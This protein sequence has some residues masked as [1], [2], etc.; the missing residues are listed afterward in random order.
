MKKLIFLCLA[1]MYAVGISAA[2]PDFS[3]IGFASMNGGTTGGKGG[4]EVTV[5]NLEQ[6]KKYVSEKDATPRIIYVK[7]TLEG[8]GGGELVAIGSNK[9]IVGI[10]T[11]GK[12]LKVQF[13]C[14]NS[15]NLIIQNLF[16]SMEGST[17]GSDADCISI[18]TTGSSKC[19]N[20]WIDHCTFDNNVSPKQNPSA[21]EKDKYD[22][23][24]D[25][26]KNTEYITVSW[27]VFK[28]HYKGILVGYTDS[29]TFDRKITMHHNAFINISSRTPSYRGGTAHIFNNYWEGSYDASVGK[30]FSTGVN[31]R[32]GA[33]LLVE[34]N[35]FKDVNKT[36]YCAIDDVKVEG[37]A[38]YRN[39]TFVNS[40]AETANTCDSFTPP[41]T[42]TIEETS[43]V[44]A[45]VTKY[46]GVGVIEDP[47][48]IPD[49][50][51]G[52]PS[53]ELDAPILGQAYDITQSGFKIDWGAVSEA[54]EYLVSLSHDVETE[55][56]AQLF[57]ESFN[58]F[59]TATVTKHGLTST[60]TDNDAGV[61][62]E[63]NGGTKMICSEDGTMVLDAGRFCITGLNLS[64]DAIL[65]LRYK[66][67][68]GS[69][70]LQ[71]ALD[72]SGSS[73]VSGLYNDVAD[74]FGSEYATLEIPIKGGTATSFIQI[75]VESSTSIIIDDIK[76]VGDGRGTE[77]KTETFRVLAPQT[78]YTFS[79]L[80][81][82]TEYAVEVSAANDKDS[83]DS[84]SIRYVT[85]LSD[86]PQSIENE[87]ADSNKII[88][89]V[90]NRIV[91]KQEGLYRI[92]NLSGK[93]VAQGISASQSD[94][95][96]LT[97]SQGCYVVTLNGIAQ[98]ALIK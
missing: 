22:G 19:Q 6:F 52:E 58:K 25:I 44:P 46:A 50:E 74:K 47:A 85:T 38:Q 30:Y 53:G 3:C 7:G 71:V 2:E 32:E 41:Y 59:T 56:G 94:E 43:S 10:G 80:E 72:I 37:Y 63:I 57:H 45:T 68:S 98:K 48:V 34:G 78:S 5:T 97:L 93:V 21:S 87:S 89:V 29:D 4:Q 81:K 20:I 64:S 39:N 55:G 42:A 95:L 8:A 67:L 12:V 82:D 33:C 1:V 84:S 92:Y 61:F 70:K 86:D 18:A 49:P 62:T 35:Y 60:L 28:N 40:G 15:Q 54:T 65:Y 51:G 83:S 11:K 75:R 91:L 96:S 16:F 36:V 77:T 31:T 69:K 14:K 9:T 24:L 73:G 17:L 76:I 13:Y 88:D 26:K 90:D 27:C 23:L 66:S 79:G